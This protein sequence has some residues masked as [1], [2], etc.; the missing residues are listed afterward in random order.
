MGGVLWF[1]VILYELNEN[2]DYRWSSSHHKKCE[3][4]LVINTPRYI[5]AKHVEVGDWPFATRKFRVK[6]LVR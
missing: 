6:P 3:V 1:T 5:F 2:R 4:E